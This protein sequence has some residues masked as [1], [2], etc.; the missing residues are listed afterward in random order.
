MAGE[1][2][3]SDGEPVDLAPWLR[4]PVAEVPRP[5]VLLSSPVQL[6]QGFVDGDSKLA[7]LSG[8]VVA[9]VPLPVGVLELATAGHSRQRAPAVLHISSVERCAAEFLCD[10]GLRRL[11]AYRLASS[12]FRGACVVLDPEVECWWPPRA[13]WSDHALGAGTAQLDDDDLTI[14]F[15]AFGGVL[16][17]FHRAEF[18]EYETCV[19][20]RAV[21]TE[22]EVAPG[23]GVHAKGI[24][25]QVIGHLGRP[26][27]GRVLLNSHGRPLA[28]VKTHSRT[29]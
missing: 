12:A 1:G 25:R 22:R 5:I 20:G 8:A 23:T 29:T 4:F 14:R 9:D 16:T 18:V 21:T 17:E 24:S 19:V 2:M 27:A 7:W 15:P 26:L 11:P 28:V 3:S 10:R 13:D 6:G